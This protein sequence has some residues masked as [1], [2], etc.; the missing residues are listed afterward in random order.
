MTHTFYYITWFIDP[1][2]Y[3]VRPY[4]LIMDIL[5]HVYFFPL[6]NYILQNSLK[7]DLAFRHSRWCWLSMLLWL[8]VSMLHLSSLIPTSSPWSSSAYK[9]LPLSTLYI[10]CL[11]HDK[12]FPLPLPEPKDYDITLSRK[13]FISTTT[14]HSLPSSSL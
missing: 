3:T 7:I 11:I 4:I 1:L 10:I 8:H 2:A 5:L 13:T 12:T 6:S 14:F 9:K